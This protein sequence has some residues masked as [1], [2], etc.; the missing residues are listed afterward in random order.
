MGIFDNIFGSPD[1][2]KLKAKLDFEGLVKLRAIPQLIFLLNDSDLKIRLRALNCLAILNDKSSINP[3]VKML[4]VGT[5]APGQ[6]QI[7]KRAA[8]ILDQ[9]GWKAESV[10]SKPS[11][12]KPYPPNP[13]LCKPPRP[14]ASIP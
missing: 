7:R 3:I 9:M 14:C 8:D 5:N 11:D 1:P 2:E 10:E 4:K 12:P 13:L 6:L